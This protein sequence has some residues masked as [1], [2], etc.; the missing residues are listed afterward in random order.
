MSFFASIKRELIRLKE[1]IEQFGET[2]LWIVA[3]S[4][5]IGGLA[6]CLHYVS[7]I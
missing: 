4:C 6:F 3:G 1:I 2:I 5:I 7:N